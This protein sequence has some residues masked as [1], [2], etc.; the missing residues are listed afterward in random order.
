MTNNFDICSNNKFHIDKIRFDQL[1]KHFQLDSIYQTIRQTILF[2]IRQ[3]SF[4]IENQSEIFHRFQMKFL[5]DKLEKEKGEYVNIKS[6]D[7]S[8]RH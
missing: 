8:L 4:H 5:L 7:F 6:F 2:D 3:H 1:T